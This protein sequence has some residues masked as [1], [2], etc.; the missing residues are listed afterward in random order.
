MNV[1]RTA[2]AWTLPLWCAGEFGRILVTMCMPVS[3]MCVCEKFE[4]C[5]H[6]CVC[7]SETYARTHRTHARTL[8]LMKREC[9]VF[10]PFCE[11]EHTMRHRTRAQVW[12][13]RDSNPYVIVYIDNMY[14]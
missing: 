8:S 6:A 5:V 1:Y 10:F 7:R 13:K 4:S 2:Y 11:R 12:L 3:V 9:T 14:A